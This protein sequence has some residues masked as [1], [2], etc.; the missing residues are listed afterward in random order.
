LI[1]GI[2]SGGHHIAGDVARLAAEP[3]QNPELHAIFQAYGT[4]LAARLFNP[5]F[6]NA[7]QTR[8]PSR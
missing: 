8:L 1:V 6:W 7:V 5:D 3:R 2:D 4:H